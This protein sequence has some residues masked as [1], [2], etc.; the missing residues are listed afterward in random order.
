MPECPKAV[1]VV[2]VLNTCP[3]KRVMS[4]LSVLVSQ[5]LLYDKGT[6]NEDKVPYTVA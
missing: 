4:I 3:F 1:V 6:S 5:T 2:V